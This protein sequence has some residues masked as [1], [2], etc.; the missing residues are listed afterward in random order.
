MKKSK[1]EETR[2]RIIKI[3][4]QIF[5][6]KGFSASRTSEIAEAAQVSEA[7][8]FKYYKS[9]QGILDAVVGVFVNKMTDRVMIEPLEGIFQ[10]NKDGPP[11]VLFRKLFSNRIVLMGKMKNYAL[12]IL[13]ESRFNDEIKGIIAQE[14]IPQIKSLGARIADHYK[15]MGILRQD[16]DSWILLRTM[17]MGAVGSVVFTEYFGIGSN[18]DTIEEELDKIIELALKGSLTDEWKIKQRGGK[19]E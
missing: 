14:I 4:A 3:A 9:K 15:E 18:Y 2:G 19:D 11:E 17:M 5:V 16:I 6:K 8:L 10:E 13:M 7:T 1:S 12:V